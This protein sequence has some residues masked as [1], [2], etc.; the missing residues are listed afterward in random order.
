L[1][2]YS[3]ADVTATSQIAVRNE[4]LVSTGRTEYPAVERFQLLYHS[5][6][7]FLDIDKPVCKARGICFQRHV[8]LPAILRL[9]SASL[10]IQYQYH[11]KALDH[12]PGSGGKGGVA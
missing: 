1:I 9:N 3:I 5:Y 2:K 6:Q 12:I 7:G 8:N 4:K 10:E 11:T